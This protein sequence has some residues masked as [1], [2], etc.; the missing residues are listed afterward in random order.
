MIIFISILLII[1]VIIAALSYNGILK[2]ADKD[3]IPDEV[4][5]KIK[6]VKNK[7]KRK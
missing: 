6:E 5:E 3:G 4:E 7:L 2:D 1:A